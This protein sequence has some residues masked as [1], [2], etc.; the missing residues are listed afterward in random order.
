MRYQEKSCGKR[1][2]KQHEEETTGIIK[3]RSPRDQITSE[4]ERKAE[5]KP[6]NQQKIK[7]KP[8]YV[9]YNIWYEGKKK[10]RK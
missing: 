9:K 2:T 10:E 5:I 7:K 8:G 1:K 4:E 3:T 6:G